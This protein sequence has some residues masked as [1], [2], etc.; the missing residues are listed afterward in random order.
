M[1]RIGL[2]ILLQLLIF[3]CFGGVVINEIMYAPTSEQGGNSYSEWIE[4]YNPTNNPINL[5][6]WELCEKELL[7]GYINHTSSGGERPYLDG[8]IILLPNQYAIITD[9]YSG[10]KVYQ[11]FNVSNNSLALHVDAASLCGKLNNDRDTINLTDNFGNLIDYV[12]YDDKWG[13]DGDGKTLERI[14]PTENSNN[15]SNWNESSIDGGTPGKLNSVANFSLVLLPRI[16]FGDGGYNFTIF[17][18]MPKNFTNANVSLNLKDK[19]NWTLTNITA[20]NENLVNLSLQTPIFNV[21]DY[22]LILNLTIFNN[23]KIISNSMQNI[24]ISP[25]RD[26]SVEL[27]NISLNFEIN[28]STDICSIIKNNGLENETNISLS[29]FVNGTRIENETKINLSVDEVETISFNYT[30]NNF[31]DYKICV[32][33]TNTTIPKNQTIYLNDEDCANITVIDPKAILCN[34]SVDIYAPIIWN[35]REGSK[36]YIFVNDSFGNYSGY[37]EII[38]WI[39]DYFSGEYIKN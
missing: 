30:F 29:F 37:P 12:T 27:I 5:S 18:A 8:G 31:G 20:G 4:L 28:K 25:R 35:N 2:F 16:I 22:E 9:G 14:N 17:I 32:K 38:Y 19:S 15:S 34:L 21:S 6:G 13:A 10:T 26:I 1:R 23:T 3:P 24:T 11:Y 36:Y 39:E 7:V 33:T